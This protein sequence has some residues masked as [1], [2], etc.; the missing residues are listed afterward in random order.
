MLHSERAVTSMAKRSVLLFK[1]IPA[2]SMCDHHEIP[3]NPQMVPG[4]GKNLDIIDPSLLKSPDRLNNV[5][6]SWFQFQAHERKVMAFKR[7]KNVYRI[8]S[9]NEQVT[10]LMPMRA[11]GHYLQVRG[12]CLYF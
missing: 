5:D 1:Q 9:N 8:S 6:K 7:A 4:Y 3:S 11:V 10:I 2:L 12:Y